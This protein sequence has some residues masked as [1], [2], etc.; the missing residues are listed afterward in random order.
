MNIIIGSKDSNGNRPADKR[1][2][3]ISKFEFIRLTD[4]TNYTIRFFFYSEKRQDNNRPYTYEHKEPYSST[5]LI[6]EALNIM[7][8]SKSTE[9]GLGSLIDT[10]V[11]DM[12]TEDV[13]K[14]DSDSI[15]DLEFSLEGSK[16]H[17]VDEPVAEDPV[18]DIISDDE[19][20]EIMNRKEEP[21]DEDL[22]KLKKYEASDK[23]VVVGWE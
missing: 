7:R 16:Y 20:N 11:D 14:T 4:G 21:T 23:N 18:D 15:P 19:Y 2:E 10:P 17:A 8:D 3:D 5:G 22:V 9:G 6:D 13:A 12:P 1:S